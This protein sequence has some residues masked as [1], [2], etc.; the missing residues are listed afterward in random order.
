MPCPWDK[1]LVLVWTLTSTTPGRAQVVGE[2]GIQGVATASDPAAGVAGAY[3]AIRT[4]GRTR[5]SAY[6]G[7]GTSDGDF[8]WRTE[9]LGYFLL[10]P[11]RRRGWG[12]YIAGGLATIGGS[13]GRGYMVLTV[14]AEER[15]RSSSGWVAEL[16]IGGGV[17]LGLGYRW[18][19][20]PRTWGK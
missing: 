19:R 4:S 15:P 1:L 2:I 3:G 8:A 5:V 11:D 10:S 13:V 7:A 17:R 20:F 12:P 14:G 16:G 18:R 9:A 6:V